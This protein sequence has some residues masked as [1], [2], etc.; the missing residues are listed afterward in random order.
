MQNVPLCH[1][2]TCYF[3]TPFTWSNPDD[4]SVY[5]GH[6]FFNTT[7]SITMLF[8]VQSLLH[9]NQ[10]NIWIK[11][12]QIMILIKGLPMTKFLLDCNLDNFATCK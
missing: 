10:P 1:L 7:K 6:S 9:H 11:I 4:V 12:I 8:I 5:M 3:N 2:F